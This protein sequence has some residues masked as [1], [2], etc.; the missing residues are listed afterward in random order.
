MHITLQH[1]YCLAFMDVC[2]LTF[3]QLLFFAV[4]QVSYPIS[5]LIRTS[6]CLVVGEC[7]DITYTPN[8]VHVPN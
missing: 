7:V 8:I 2:T 3:K 6:P 4:S 1:Y 5:L